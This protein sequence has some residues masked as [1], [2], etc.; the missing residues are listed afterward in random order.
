M[1]TARILL[2]SGLIAGITAVAV[3][4]AIASQPIVAAQEDCAEGET[5]NEQTGKCEPKQS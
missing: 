2:A 3:Q 5:W 4:P 1:T